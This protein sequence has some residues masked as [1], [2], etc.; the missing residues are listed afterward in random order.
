MSNISDTYFNRFDPAKNFDSH[1][2]RAGYAVQSAEFNELQS[3]FSN[4]VKG[5]ADALFRDGDVIRDA[6]VVVNADIGSITCESGAVYIKG[7]VRGIAPKAM[8]IPVVGVVTVGVYLQERIVTELED[9]TLRDPAPFTRNYQEPGAARL[10]AEI[11]WGFSGDGQDGEFFPVYEVLD[12]VLKS[13][14]APPNLDSVN[15][16]IATYDRDNSGGTYVING[17][18]V[19]STNSQ[20]TGIDSF[21]ISSGRARVY[22]YAVQF[23][24]DSRL[25]REQNPDLRLINAEPHLADESGSQRINLDRSPAAEILEVQTTRQKTVNLTRG[26]VGGG[27]DVLPDSSILKLISVKQGGTTYAIGTDLRLTSGKVDWSLTGAEPSGGSTYTV[28]YEYISTVIP[29]QDDYDEDGLTV[30]GA[31]SGS[32]ILLTYTAKLPRIDRLC[33]DRDGNFIWATGVSDDYYPREPSVPQNTLSLC[34]VI[35]TWRTSQLPKVLNDAVRTMSMSEL[36][37]LN[38][39]ID[40]IADMMAR[41]QLATD[42]NLRETVLKKGLLVD[43]FIDNSVRDFGYDQTATIAYGALSLPIES[44][45]TVLDGSNLAPNVLSRTGFIQALKQE[46]FTGGMKINPYMSF[47]PNPATIV[48]NPAKDYWT[49]TTVR[50]TSNTVEKNIVTSSAQTAYLASNY[51]WGYGSYTRYAGSSTS[52][53]SSVSSSS[54]TTVTNQKLG[55]LENL[56]QIDVTVRVSGF[57]PNEPLTEMRFDGLTVTPTAIAN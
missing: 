29:G 35:N 53:S 4:R 9:P 33:I 1:M 18:N 54:A 15:H 10:F 34:K 2:F 24:A 46:S 23:N 7:Q 36:Q 37:H 25:N 45:A 40:G 56:R 26:M 8:A 41:N 12:G 52:V 32:L 44:M 22:G 48:L 30:T 6:S 27:S 19:E 13:K 39:R 3:N 50:E 17:F 57:G 51:Y 14:D 43:P 31:V 49:E 47:P 42:A 55:D 21:V 5:V 16:A 38:A 20:N 11:V 28:I